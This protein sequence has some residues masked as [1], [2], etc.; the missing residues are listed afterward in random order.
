MLQEKLKFHLN[1]K[2]NVNFMGNKNSN[3]SFSTFLAI[4]GLI[5][6]EFVNA[7]NEK[8][9]MYMELKRI[10][11]EQVKYLISN[12]TWSWISTLNKQKGLKFFYHLIPR[13]YIS[14]MNLISYRAPQIL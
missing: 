2:E 3:I 4:S 12:L 5:A 8:N 10:Y 9:P 6:F 1:E 14:A 13:G 7:D 11:A